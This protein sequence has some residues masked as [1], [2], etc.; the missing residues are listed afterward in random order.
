MA[1]LPSDMAPSDIRTAPV[2]RAPVSLAS[3]PWSP[4]RKE[5][6]DLA[7]LPLVQEGRLLEGSVHDLSRIQLQ[8][9]VQNRRVDTAEVHAGVQVALNQVF[10]LEGGVLTIVTTL[11]PL[12]EH[13]GRPRG[14]VIR[15]RAVVV[16]SA[17]ELREQQ[18][19]DIVG[20][21]VRAKI[22]HEG[23]EPLGHRAPQG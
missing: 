7:I 10:G 22:C 17:A 16:N 21:I 12:T 11:D 9:L 5:G 23:L 4:P 8:P 18:D 14:A 6:R 2:H 20:V 3:F 19:Y 13:E 15:P 1:S